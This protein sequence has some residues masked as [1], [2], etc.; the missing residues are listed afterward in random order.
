MSL[1]SY[2]TRSNFEK[3]IR[4]YCKEI[5]WTITEIDAD[6]AKLSFDMESGRTQTLHIIRF[7]STLEFSV[8]SGIFFKE[9]DE[10]PGWISTLLMR[11]NSKFKVG[12][13][14]LETIKGKSIFSVMH[15]A[16]Q[17]LINRDYFEGIVGKLVETCDTFEQVMD[18]ALSDEDEEQDS[19]PEEEEE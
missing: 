14:C 2:F 5:G 6:Y 15:N 11:E 8:P 18:R 7:D 4:G 10:V 12:F 13:W 17:S 16:E 19:T 9:E 1:L 3:T